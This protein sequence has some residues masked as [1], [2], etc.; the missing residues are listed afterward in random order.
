MRLDGERGTHFLCYDYSL[1]KECTPN[2]QVFIQESIA[3]STPVPSDKL[4]DQAQVTQLM[5]AS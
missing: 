1:E 5:C 4:C 3:H 2:P